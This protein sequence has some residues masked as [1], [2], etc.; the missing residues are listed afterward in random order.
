[1]AGNDIIMRA[2]RVSHLH[3]SG[4]LPA[5]SFPSTMIS[6]YTSDVI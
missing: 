4:F 2:Y 3:L 6:L 1:M 5:I